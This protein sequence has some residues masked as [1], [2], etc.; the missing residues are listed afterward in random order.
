M[1]QLAGADL[2]IEAANAHGAA[3]GIAQ[4]LK[5]FHG[6][7]FACAV[8]AE[9]TEDFALVHSEAEATHG[10]HIAVV[11]HEIVYLQNGIGHKA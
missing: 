11:L 3:I 1:F 6:S 8:G 5:D 7:G 9:Q 2:R 4:A 10:L